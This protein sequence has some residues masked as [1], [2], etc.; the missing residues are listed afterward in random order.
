MT[1]KLFESWGVLG[2]ERRPVYSDTIPA[3]EHYDIITVDIPYPL[4]ENEMG[5][6]LIDIDGTT[7]LLSEVLTDCGDAPCIAIYDG[8]QM[9]R[10]MLEV[11]K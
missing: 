10:I 2:K 8:H 9:R 6:T 3:T 4:A 1:Y 11:I 5:E 7:Y